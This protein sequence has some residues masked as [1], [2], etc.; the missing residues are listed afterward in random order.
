LVLSISGVH[1][2]QALGFVAAAVEISLHICVCS[3]D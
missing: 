1:R 2:H 3:S